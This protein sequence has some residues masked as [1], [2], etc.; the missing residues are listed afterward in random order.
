[1]W[2][3]T[4]WKSARMT[5]AQSWSRDWADVITSLSRRHP[6]RFSNGYISLSKKQYYISSLCS[7]KTGMNYINAKI[8]AEICMFTS[9]NSQGLN[10][11]IL[12]L[13][14]LMTSAA[15]DVIS[16]PNVNQG[17]IS[18]MFH[19]LSKIISQKKIYDARNHIYGYNL[20]LKLWICAHNMALGTHTKFQLQI[21]IK[22]YDFCNTQIF[23]R[24]FWRACEMLV[25]HHPGSCFN[26]IKTIF[27]SMVSSIIKTVLPLFGSPYT[28]K[29]TFLYLDDP[30]G[31]CHALS[32]GTQSISRGRGISTFKRLNGA[33]F[34]ATAPLIGS[35][36]FQGIY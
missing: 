1:M 28:G 24:I 23:E 7:P 26:N 13:L 15:A 4:V 19:K 30:L 27:P 36:W 32:V 3:Q 29:M 22:K 17:V 12:R 5:S 8:Q 18:L 20:K 35:S 14:W 11:A 6:C 10:R 9:Q 21:L 31:L 25:K 33:L 34:G 2:Y 16:V